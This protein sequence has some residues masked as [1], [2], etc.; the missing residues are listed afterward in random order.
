MSLTLLLTWL[1]SLTFKD[2]LKFAGVLLMCYGL[3]Q[4]YQFA[5]HKG[6][7]AEH[8]VM[9]PQLEKAQLAAKKEQDELKDYKEQYIRWVEQSQKAQE[10]FAKE[11]KQLQQSLTEQLK[12]AQKRAQQREVTPRD[13]TN[14][15]TQADDA[16][17]T[18]PLTFGLLHNQ[19]IE[20]TPA[21]SAGNV[22]P[23]TAASVQNAPSSLTLS[24]YA[25]VAAYNNSEAVRRGE[26]IALWERW[27]EETKAQFEKAQQPHQGQLPPLSAPQSTQTRAEHP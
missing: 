13:I 11:Q 10:Q 12:A 20:G 27:Y 14:Y 15:I 7:Q 6:Q 5:Y 4:G 16:H 8:A 9:A 21:S 25:A 22:L 26:I 18:V 24:Q 2:Y 3:Y 19:S 17:C 23:S 1:K